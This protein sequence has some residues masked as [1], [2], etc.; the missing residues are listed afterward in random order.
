MFK[1]SN[2]IWVIGFLVVAC[3]AGSILASVALRKALA[4]PLDITTPTAEVEDVTLKPVAVQATT[5]QV[6]VTPASSGSCGQKGSTIIL[7]LAYDTKI[8]PPF[9]ADGVRLVRV[10]YDKHK[11]QVLS[12]PRDLWV[13][14][15]VQAQA[16]LKATT[17]GQLYQYG[18]DNNKGTEVEIQAAAANL[19]AQALYD[20]FAFLPDHYVTIKLNVFGG[21]IDAIDGIDINLPAAYTAY[22][23]TFKAGAQ[24]WDSDTA[25]AYIRSLDDKDTE[26]A[27]FDRQ[28]Q[29]LRAIQSS[30]KDEAT[31]S[32]IPELTSQFHE[33]VVTDL[34]LAQIASLSCITQQLSLEQIV[35]SEISSDM[36]L[37]GPDNAVLPDMEKIKPFLLTWST[38]K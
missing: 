27:R 16:D 31:L 9:G 34:S 38:G 4:P 32:L 5:V 2:T 17:L 37:P 30:M 3:V 33:N 20:N 23:R 18:L 11:I 35:F 7:L 6:E 14:A 19:V 15:P 29:V 22:G 25:L 13:V 28:N 21:L 8:E 36:V 1:I 24:H 12:F 10:D 26:W